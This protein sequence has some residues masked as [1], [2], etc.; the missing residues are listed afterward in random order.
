MK[1]FVFV[2]FSFIFSLWHPSTATAQKESLVEAKYIIVLDIQEHFTKTVLNPD[3]S[4][5]LIQIINQVIDGAE[6]QNVIYIQSLLSNLSVSLS[7]ISVEF[8]PGLKFDERLKIVNTN[9]FGKNKANAFS[10]EELKAFIKSRKATD[11]VVIGLMAEHCVLHTL[12]GGKNLG[13]SMFFVP[14]AIAG[15][16]DASKEKIFAQLKQEGIQ[17]IPFHSIK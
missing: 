10:S 1:L 3:V 5:T 13:Y 9:I 17:A 16:S 11:F 6:P 12:L 15:K 14:E 4:D 8:S 2:Y 7:G